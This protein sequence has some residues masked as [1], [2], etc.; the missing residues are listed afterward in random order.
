MF[1]CKENNGLL[2]LKPFLFFHGPFSVN[3]C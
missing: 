1:C 2:N 3:N